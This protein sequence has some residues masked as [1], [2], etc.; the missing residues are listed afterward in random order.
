MR[1]RAKREDKRSAVP[2][3]HVILRQASI[4]RPIA[5]F[6]TEI[7][8]CLPSRRSNFGGRPLPDHFFG[9]RGPVPYGR[10]WLDAG[11]IVQAEIC[12]ARTQIGISAIAGVHQHYATRQAPCTGPA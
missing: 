9:A 5:S 3:R 1:T 7:G 11:H 2:S 4:G 12:D 6:L 8:W 10:L